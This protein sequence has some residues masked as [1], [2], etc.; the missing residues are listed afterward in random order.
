MGQSQGPMVN[1]DKIYIQN[2]MII[3]NISKRWIGEQSSSS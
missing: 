3:Q 1:E 2:N